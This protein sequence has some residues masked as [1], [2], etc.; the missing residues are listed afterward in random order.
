MNYQH[1]VNRLN[2]RAEEQRIRKIEDGYAPLWLII[3]GMILGIAAVTWMN[4]A[5]ADVGYDN[6]V[7]CLA[8]N[9]YH[10]AQ[11][12][13]YEGRKAVAFVV[14]ERMR[15]NN[16]DVCDVVFSREQFSWTNKAFNNSGTLLPEFIP[17]NTTRWKKAQ[18]VARRAMG[19]E[20]RNPLPGATHYHAAYVTPSWA[21]SMI[22][23]GRIGT[24]IF[25]KERQYA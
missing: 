20:V 21:A 1:I 8:L 16:T 11:F 5:N 13:P 25:Y 3:Y 14:I 2:H 6:A 23:L 19:G 9:V 24:H 15:K 12:E 17:R 10:E 7:N 22:Y 4:D 18:Y